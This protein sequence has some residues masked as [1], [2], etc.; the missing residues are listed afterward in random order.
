MEKLRGAEREL[1]HPA[2]ASFSLLVNCT[3]QPPSHGI[4]R[5]TSSSSL[6]ITNRSLWSPALAIA[7]ASYHYNLPLFFSRHTFSNV[8]K[9]TSPKLSHTTWISIQQNL[10]YSD[11]FEVPPKTNGGQK[12]P[13][14]A[15]F[16][17]PSRK[18]L[19]P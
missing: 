9:P 17:M 13:K 7:R 16:F 10:C 8:G 4:A 5:P 1:V 19:A 11:F 12:K 2:T 18:E 14:F 15:P 3:H 6:K